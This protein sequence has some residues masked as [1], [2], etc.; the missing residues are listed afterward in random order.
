MQLWRH[1]LACQRSSGC[2]GPEVA[3]ACYTEQWRLVRLEQEREAAV[4][5][6]IRLRLCRACGHGKDLGFLT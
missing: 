1:C 3:C 2:K 6:L 4:T 5:V